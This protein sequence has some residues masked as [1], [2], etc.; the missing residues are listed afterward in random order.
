MFRLTRTKL[1]PIALLTAL[2]LSADRALIATSSAPKSAG[3]STERAGDFP[4]SAL[5]QQGGLIEIPGESTFVKWTP[6]YFDALQAAKRD[7]RALFLYFSGS[8][9]CSYCQKFDEQ[10]LSDPKFLTLVDSRFS[11]YKADFPQGRVDNLSQHEENQNLLRRFQV[12]GFP[13]VL[14]LDWNENVLGRFHF[15][16]IGAEEFARKLLALPQANPPPASSP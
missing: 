6:T 8:N 14:V 13:T 9:W 5:T 7:H 16:D 11:F 3:R 10:V 2:G 12:D 4:P 1:I 15:E